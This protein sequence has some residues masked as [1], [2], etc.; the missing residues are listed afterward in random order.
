MNPIKVIL[1]YK[2]DFKFRQAKVEKILRLSDGDFENI[3][4]S[5]MEYQDFIKENVDLMHKDE[6]GVYHCLLVTGENHRDG[7]LV[8]AE[9]YGYARYAS[10]VPDAA[11]L[12]YD[13]LSEIGYR[14]SF[15]VDQFVTEG[16]AAA[17]GGRWEIPFEDIREQSG[18]ELWENPFLQELMA[19][20]IL[21]RPEIAEVGIREDCFSVRCRPEFCHDRQKE[22][23]PEYPQTDGN[24]QSLGDL[25]R[26][27]MQADTYL[28]HKS[29]VGFI[30][31][32]RV[33]SA[34]L[35]SGVLDDYADL[36]NAG[37]AM[38]R[39][40]SYGQEI[41]LEGVSASRL[42]EFDQFLAHSFV[43]SQAQTLKPSAPVYRRLSEMLDARWENLHLVHHEID[44]EPHTIVELDAGTLTEAGREAWADVLDAKVLRVFQ[45]IYGLQMELSGVKAS[46]LD[47][48]SAML[49]GYCSEQDYDRWV[50]QTED[51]MTG[52]VMTEGIP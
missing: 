2:P 9:G 4:Q 35:D 52:P 39:Q 27:G 8:E 16:Q 29:D 50:S 45:G 18:L 48:F 46:R 44:S 6:S 37:I 17:S 11:A 47:D 34:D 36:L 26:S 3:L 12:A 25:I 10:Y 23:V 15:L 21:E 49:A 31:V 5:P 7:V 20:M 1:E 42:T 13:S 40:G 41:E 19:D 22:R 14:L 51:E 33:G 28:I 32:G 30:P 38:M 43:E 24:R